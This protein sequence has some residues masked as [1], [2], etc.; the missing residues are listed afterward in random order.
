MSEDA[1]GMSTDAAGVLTPVVRFR[2]ANNIEYDIDAPEAP[3]EVG[4][5]V[6][7][8]YDPALPSGGQGVDRAP[9]ILIPIVLIVLGAILV[10]VGAS[11]D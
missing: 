1:A 11:R 5:E 2:A 9:K 3:R 6:E 8:A 10:A 7:V 4:T